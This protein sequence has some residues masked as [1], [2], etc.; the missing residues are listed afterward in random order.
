M[1]DL[2]AAQALATQ[3]GKQ[4]GEMT[5]AIERLYAT[6][7]G[8]ALVIARLKTELESANAIL[9]AFHDE[10]PKPA[11]LRKKRRARR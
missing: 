4:V 7:G 2:E 10:I 11:I 6:V 1:T 9:Q 3:R 5:N 8:Q